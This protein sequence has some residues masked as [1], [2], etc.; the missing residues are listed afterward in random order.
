[1]IDN[2]INVGMAS[3]GLSGRVFHAPL[4]A[5]H[6]SFRIN[7]IVERNK[8]TAKAIYPDIT[9]S[10]SFDELLTDD[11][12]DLV[13][14]NT[15]DNTHFEFARKALEAGKHVVVE[16]P[17]TQTIE[18]AEQL[19]HIATKARRI[20]SVFQNRRW[21][22]DFLTAQQIVRENTLG[23]LVEYEARRDRYLNSLRPNTWKEEATSGAGMLTDLGSHLVDQAVVLFGMPDAVTSHLN[24]IR[25]GSEIVDWFEV[26]LHYADKNVAVRGS[27]LAREPAPRYVLH[28]T[29]GTFVKHGV[30][31]QEA[32][33]QQGKN[34]TDAGW[35]MEPAPQWGLLTTE[36][37][38]TAFRGVVQTKPG[39]YAAYYDSIANAIVNGS[40]PAVKPEEALNVVRII[41]AAK[42][43][44]D[45]KRT[46]MLLRD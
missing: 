39:N 43:S 41:A 31:P 24:T 45:H 26:R 23:R 42:Q 28:G 25:T 12:I 8:N 9:P 40:Q 32:M 36:K 22:G 27:Y 1:M 5:H 14:V 13:I 10:R 3:F 2:K 17:F 34:P 46:V 4:L 16:K 15:P 37:D 35:G 7:R 18:E 33:L 21:D 29:L 6:K 38:G 30:D 20:L 44:H 11:E 19:L